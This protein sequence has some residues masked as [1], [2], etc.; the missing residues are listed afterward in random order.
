MNAISRIQNQIKTVYSKLYY[1]TEKDYTE[2]S[3]DKKE[4][5]Q[6]VFEL[7]NQYNQLDDSE[8]A[9]FN[10]VETIYFSDIAGFWNDSQ[11]MENKLH[12]WLILSEYIP[13]MYQ[14]I[15]KLNKP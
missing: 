7:I 8:K 10:D 3:E 6:E 1:I 13:A 9:I 5:D 14:N 12:A 15:S 2:N 4:I 11:K